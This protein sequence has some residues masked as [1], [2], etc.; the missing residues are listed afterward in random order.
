MNVS[1]WF[2]FEKDGKTVAIHIS[3]G[4]FEKNILNILSD[5]PENKIFK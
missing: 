5:E 4:S 1:E 3:D 2:V